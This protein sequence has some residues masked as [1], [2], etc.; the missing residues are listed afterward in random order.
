MRSGWR[1]W[2]S[3]NHSSLVWHLFKL[4]NSAQSRRFSIN[5]FRLF[6]GILENL[7]FTNTKMWYTLFSSRGEVFHFTDQPLFYFWF[8][9]YKTHIAWRTPSCVNWSPL[10]PP[11]PITRL[12]QQTNKPLPVQNLRCLKP[13]WTVRRRVR[14]LRM[15]LITTNNVPM[16]AHGCMVARFFTAK[17]TFNL[18]KPFKEICS[19]KGFCQFRARQFLFKS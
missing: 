9:P 10:I 3:K 15:S 7:I 6:R 1:V 12:A 18:F 17:Q 19:L 16:P 5:A 13:L 14:V 2:F 4:L 11:I 8:L